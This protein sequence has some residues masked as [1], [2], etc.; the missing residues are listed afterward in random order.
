ME[1]SQCR[2]CITKLRSKTSAF[3]QVK[4]ITVADMLLAVGG[5]EVRKPKMLFTNYFS[6]DREAL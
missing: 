2:V 4:E 1:D 3:K 5:I 6:S